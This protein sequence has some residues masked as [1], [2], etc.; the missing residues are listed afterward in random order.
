[1]TNANAAAQRRWREKQKLKKRSDLTKTS[2]QTDVFKAPFWSYLPEDYYFSSDF[3]DAFDLLGVPAP[4][5]ED[6]L[7]PEAFSLDEGAE[8]AGIFVSTRRSLGRAEVMVGSL[9]TAAVDLA[10][11]INA[12]KKQEIA[13]RLEELAEADLADTASRSAAMAEAAM[14]NRMLDQLNAQIRWS[15]P[16]WK[17]KS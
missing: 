14:L 6:D 17:V 12:Y 3:A 2:D 9:I 4:K 5:F 13:R 7:G 11:F 8:E 1:M 10:S 15:F 16:Q